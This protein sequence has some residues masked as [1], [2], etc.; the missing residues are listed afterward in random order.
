LSR[1]RENCGF[2]YHLGCS[3]NN[4]AALVSYWRKK[5]EIA[6]F[7]AIIGAIAA[8]T[9][10]IAVLAFLARSI[11][12]HFLSQD[13]EK[14]KNSLESEAKIEIESYPSKLENEQIRL[15]ISHSG[16]FEKQAMVIIEIYK[17]IDF[18]YIEFHL[19]YAN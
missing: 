14:F 13:I 2:S 6:M 1:R 16:I 3:R 12:K 9:I 10:A 17:L 11:I 7:E 8:N 15:Q 19:V 4:T 5:V 18:K